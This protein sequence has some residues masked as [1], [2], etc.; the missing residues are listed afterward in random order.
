MTKILCVSVSVLLV[1]AE[2][3]Q[4]RWQK[5]DSCSPFSLFPTLS[6]ALHYDGDDHFVRILERTNA[7]AMA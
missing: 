4:Q 5:A 7:L 2:K 3:Q 1:K 6:F